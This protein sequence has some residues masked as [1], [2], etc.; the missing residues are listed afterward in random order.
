M[1]KKRVGWQNTRW[2]KCSCSYRRI[3]LRLIF[4][5][6]SRKEA[7]PATGS[8][9]PPAN[10][11][12]PTLCR[13]S[14]PIP[15]TLCFLSQESH[16]AH[17]SGRMQSWHANLGQKPN[18]AQYRYWNMSIPTQSHTPDLPRTAPWGSSPTGGTCSHFTGLWPVC[19]NTNTIWYYWVQNT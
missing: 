4:H 7:W 2:N 14:H 13:C 18:A 11:F 9:F 1:L 6:P 5:R 10:T 19:H 8:N 3:S 12:I 17:F 16:T 15:N